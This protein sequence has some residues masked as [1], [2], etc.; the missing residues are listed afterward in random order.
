MKISIIITVLENR[1][2]LDEA[3]KSALSQDFDDYEIILAS[4]GNPEMK[5]YADKWGLRFS[6]CKVR[7]HVSKN[8]NIAA[9]M[10]KGKFLKP[11]SDDDLLPT[12]CIKDLYLNI[13][14]V[15]P[16]CPLIFANAIDFWPSGN[17]KLRKP[18]MRENLKELIKLKSSYIHGGTIMFRKD[19]FLNSG[20]F[21]E[22]LK[23]CEE[24]DYYLKLLSKDYKFAYL[25]KVV[26]R[27]RKHDKQKGRIANTP[28]R[29]KDKNYI[30]NK[31]L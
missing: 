24:Y 23:C 26:Y 19:I 30:V 7:S 2:W 25:D 10:A 20:G 4:D 17:T 22:R 16:V 28:E 5:K 15:Y 31:Y 9:R 14:D 8:F 29:M 6:L 27:Y 11:L 21:D 13:K 12:N 3:I 18:P 1:G